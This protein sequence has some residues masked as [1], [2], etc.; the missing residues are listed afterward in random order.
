MNA[1]SAI[2]P[3]Y[4]LG[5][6][7]SGTVPEDS[8]SI[9]E[10]VLAAVENALADGGR[11]HDDVDAVVSASVDL[12]DGLT[13]SNIAITEVVGAVMKPESRIS[14]DGLAAALHA[15]CQI[16][17]GA[18]DTVLV[19]AHAKA[20]MAPFDAL[21]RWAMDP[22]YLQP[23]G[24][25]FVTCSALQA[26]LVAGVEPAAEQRWAEQAARRRSARDSAFGGARTTREVLASPMLSTPLREGMRA[27]LGDG[28]CAVLLG[29]RPG[30][31]PSPR[32]AGIG[33]DMDGH[34]PG[35][36][37]LSRWAALSRALARARSAADETV[38]ATIDLAE[39]SC[40]YPHEED[41][42]RDAAGLGD[43]TLLSPD[44]GLFPGTAP[45]VAGLSRLVAAVQRMRDDAAC[46]SA[47]AHGAWGPAGQAHAVA[48]LRAH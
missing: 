29:T 23:L 21:S 5:V 6:G 13:A 44:G 39:P 31:A 2:G 14:S 25:D 4:V 3:V 22:I 26:A 28:A 7:E 24:L 12:F 17:A 18:Y 46:R 41:L 27:P 47:L 15:V 30:R 38:P 43:S 34:L 33:W 35:E 19:V 37:D 16:R 20:S 36:R 45:V 48:L 40:M 11:D 9:A 32:V 42:F 8:R 1:G 10:M